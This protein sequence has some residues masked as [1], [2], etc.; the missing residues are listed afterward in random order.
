M[1]EAGIVYLVDDDLAVREA[2]SSLIRS[3]GFEVLAFANAQ[4][5]LLTSR[6]DAPS[7]IVLDV[8]LPDLSGLDLQ[9]E[10]LNTGQTL[11]VIFITAHGDIPM[12]VRAMKAGAIEFL[13]KPIRDEELLDAIRT[14]LHR[15]ARRRSERTTHDDIQGRWD[16]LTPRERQV[17]TRILAGQLNKQV[18]ADLGV[19]EIT[20][21]I[22]RRNVLRKMKVSSLVALAHLVGHMTQH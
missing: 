9:R 20:V 16:R 15:D 6:G 21:K 17:A 22:H 2:L 12:T 8:R 3:A 1:S 14:G 19:S 5:F 10:L 7:C 13:P 4:D 18:A 11:P